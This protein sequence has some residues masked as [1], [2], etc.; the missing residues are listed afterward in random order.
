MFSVRRD[1]KTAPAIPVSVGMRIS[2]ISSPSAT[3]ENSSFVFRS[4]RKSVLRSAPSSSVVACM[5][6]DSSRSRFSSPARSWDSCRMRTSSRRLASIRLKPR[7]SSAYSSV[8]LSFRSLPR[9]PCSTPRI[10]WASRA[11]ERDTSE[12]VKTDMA[13]VPTMQ[14]RTTP[15]AHDRIGHICSKRA[16]T[17]RLSSSR[18]TLKTMVPAKN[19]RGSELRKMDR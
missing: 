16:S 4:Y 10:A 18:S 3:R 17:P 15:T 11:A 6:R 7:K 2:R 1:W 13:R 12:A 14:T 8:E 9:S 19:S 5:S